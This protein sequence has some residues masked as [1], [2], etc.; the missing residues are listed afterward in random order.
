MKPARYIGQAIEATGYEITENDVRCM[1][2]ATGSFYS[3]QEVPPTYATL[4]RKPEY[5]WLERLQVDLKM[6]L[7][8]DQEYE[9]LLPL[10]IGQK[11][12]VRTVL[13]DVKDRKTR[14]GVMSFVKVRTELI[15]DKKIHVVGRNT[16]VVRNPA[17]KK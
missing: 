10:R 14:L 7:H 12:D 2:E 9:Y 17:W 11:V 1:R 8:G 3:P 5:D 6:L 15:S 16:F 4:F 13:E